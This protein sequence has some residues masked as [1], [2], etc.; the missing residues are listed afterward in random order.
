MLRLTKQNREKILAKN[1][2]FSRNTYYEGNNFRESRNYKISDG[3]L[4]IR[5][6]GKTSWSD[7]HFQ[8][9]WIADEE[10]THRFLYKYLDELDTDGI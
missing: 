7:S 1:E 6:S 2:G 9:E 8:D 3:R 10:E 5:S 4:I